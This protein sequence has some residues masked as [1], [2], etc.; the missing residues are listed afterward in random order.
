MRSGN[1]EIVKLDLNLYSNNSVLFIKAVIL[2]CLTLV[3]LN[4]TTY[5]SEKLS[6]KEIIQSCFSIISSVFLDKRLLEP[7]R[8]NISNDRDK[9]SRNNFI[10]E[11]SNLYNTELVK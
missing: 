5:T 1:I 8:L 3:L 10:L 11:N 4:L 9:L 7:L 6:D 2:V